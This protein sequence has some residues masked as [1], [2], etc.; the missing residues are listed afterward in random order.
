MGT[1][2][3]MIALWKG[4]TPVGKQS[5]A[6]VDF[7]DFYPTFA[8]AAG[9]KLDDSDLKDGLSLYP[10]LVGETGP[11]RKWA[12]CHYQPYW[13]KVPGQ[14]I[15]TQQYKLYRDG[16]FFDIGSGDLDESKD[17]NEGSSPASSPNFQQLKTLIEKAPTAPT[18]KGNKSTID[19]P[20]YP[21]W[22]TMDPR[23]SQTK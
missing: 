19:R 6:L 17:L 10:T 15:R 23:V 3:P 20:T 2:V 5:D 18:G 7:T 4:H 12:F 9:I 21:D 16:R 14:F 8:E 22:P 1:H 13:N 11:Q